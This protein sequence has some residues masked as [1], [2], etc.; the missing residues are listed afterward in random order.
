VA[1]KN[2]GQISFEGKVLNDDD[3]ELKVYGHLKT[4]QLHADAKRSYDKAVREYKKLLGLESLEEPTE[5][6]IHGPEGHFVLHFDPQPTDGHSVDAGTRV[7]STR[8]F[9][10][11]DGV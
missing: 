1:I 11:G 4:M 5:I 2:E 6:L 10:T 9:V 8:K 3:L 7:N